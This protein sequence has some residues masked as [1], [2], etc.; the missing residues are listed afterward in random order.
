[1][2]LFT[3]EIQRHVDQLEGDLKTTSNTLKL[4]PGQS[5]SHCQR[6]LSTQDRLVELKAQD[7]NI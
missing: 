2:N 4:S 6:L 7:A 5:Q 1:M 3:H